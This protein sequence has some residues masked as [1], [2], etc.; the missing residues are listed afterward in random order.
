QAAITHNTELGINAACAAA[1]M[2]HYFLYRVGAKRALGAWLEEQVP[3]EWNREYT[4]EVKSLGWMSVRA[5]VTAIRRC[6]SLVTLLQK[7]VNIG[8]DV[9][10]VAAIALGAAAGSE[11]MRKDLPLQL[12]EGLENGPFGRDYLVALDKRLLGLMARV[13]PRD[14]ADGKEQ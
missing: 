3:G 4:G 5:A 2:A 11:E 1:L 8:G 6:D 12:V 13:E 10:T 14:A 9:D 7:C